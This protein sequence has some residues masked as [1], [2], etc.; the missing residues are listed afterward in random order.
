MHQNSASLLPWPKAKIHN[1]EPKARKVAFCANRETNTIQ[2]ISSIPDSAAKRTF[3]IVR[4]RPHCW[5]KEDD[6]IYMIPSQN[7]KTATST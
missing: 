4:H 1:L 6:S 5:P 7:Q 3:I 2:S